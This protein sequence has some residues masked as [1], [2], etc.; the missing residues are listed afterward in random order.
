[1]LKTFLANT[2]VK[3]FKRLGFAGAL[4]WRILYWIYKIWPGLHIRDAEWDWVLNYLPKLNKWKHV[5]ILVVGCTSSLFVYE[6]VRRGYEVDG[7]DIRPY[8]EKPKGFCYI[9][10]DITNLKTSKIFQ[11]ESDFKNIL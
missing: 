5:S 10:G 3:W 11:I 9:S 4:R 1:M 8:Q 6:L 7:I 2:F